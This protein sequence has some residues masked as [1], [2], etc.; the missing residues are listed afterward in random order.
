M[1]DVIIIGAGI[2]G[3]A[4]A[5]ELSKY[6]LSV[7]VLDKNND[8]ANGT[9]MANSAIVH[10]GYDAEV[11]KNK[12]KFNARGNL[13]YPQ[14]CKELDVPFK[15][16]G[17]LVIGFDDADMATLALLKVRG[18]ENQVPGLKLLTRNEVIAMEPNI[19]PEVRGALYAPTA[20]IVSAWEMAI[21]MMENAMDNGVSLHLEHE[22]QS[23][24]KLDGIFKVVTDKETLNSRYI[25]NCAGV[26]A[27]SINE[28]ISTSSYTIRPRKGEYYILDKDQGEVVNHVIFQ[29]PS[30][31]GKGILVAPTVHGNLLVGPDS[32][33]IDDKEDI[34]T[35]A[36][37]LQ[38]I[39]KTAEKTTKAIDFRKVIRSFS[40]LR[41]CSEDFDFIIG[42]S[43]DVPGF[44]NIGGFESPGLSAA[45]AVA[46][47]IVKDMAGKD[48]S[49]VVDEAYNPH[50][51]PFI[52]F[53]ELTADEKSTLI[54]ENPLYGRVI[55]RCE[56]ITEGE[57][58][59]AIRRNGGATTVKGVK[60]RT[61]AGMGRCQGG[62]CGPRVVEI[63]SREL[64]IDYTQVAYDQSDAYL[65]SGRTKEVE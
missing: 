9:T 33:F 6:Q 11:Y 24:E 19:N 50:R 39:R 2:A 47:Y 16:I 7:A 44:Y 13:M 32:E 62:F 52:R 27:D 29:C 17:S 57:I 60:K 63:L 49:F 41:A 46:E 8:I 31:K 4:V 59:D 48:D 15:Q 61:R 12:G 21:G 5:R 26:Y 45:P 22:V 53:D 40:G 3:A 18:D 51:R 35:D 36:D 42:E 25:V 34:S 64:N 20:G 54:R 38:L 55:C 56:M 10:A 65:L 14:L 37:K 1:Y 30:S 28:M 43:E 58:V 23:I